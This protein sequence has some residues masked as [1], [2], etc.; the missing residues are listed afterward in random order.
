MNKRTNLILALLLLLVPNLW[1]QKRIKVACVGNSITEGYLLANPK[2]ES[3]PAVL[4]RL[5]GDGYEVGNFGHSG[6]TLL[7]EGHRPYTETDAFRRAMAFDADIFVVHLGLN[8]TDPRNWPNIKHLFERDYRKLLDTLGTQA[9]GKKLYIAQLSPLLPEHRRYYASSHAWHKEVNQ[10]I[11]NMA[12]LKYTLL[13]FSAPFSA[14]WHLFPDALHPNAEGAKLLGEYVYECIKPKTP[15]KLWLHPYYRDNMIIQKGRVRIHGKGTAGN[16]L[17]YRIDDKATN[18]TTIGPDGKWFIELDLKK[19]Q[20]FNLTLSDQQTGEVRTIR[21]IQV[22]EV[23]VASGQSN[24]QWTLGQTKDFDLEAAPADSLLHYVGM[25]AIAETYNV[26]WSLPVLDSINAFQYVREYKFYTAA[27]K[28][29]LKAWSAVGYHFGRKLRDSLQ[30]PVAIICNA[31]GGSPIEAWLNPAH[32]EEYYPD[33][34][35]SWHKKEYAEPWVRERTLKNIALRPTGQ[36]H[37]YAPGYLYQS[38]WVP[39]KD[40]PRR[41][42]IWYQGESNAHASERYAKHFDELLDIYRSGQSHDRDNVYAV[43][44]S[45]IRRPSWVNF[46]VAQANPKHLQHYVPAYDLGHPDDVHPQYKKPVG[47]RLALRALQYTYEHRLRSE[48]PVVAEAKMAQTATGAEIY[49]RLDQTWGGI[50][51]VEK[52]FVGFELMLPSGKIVEPKSIE[53]YQP[54]KKG[55]K[56]VAHLVIRN[57]PKANYLSVRYIGTAY[58]EANVKAGNG[59]PLM[60][61]DWIQIA[62]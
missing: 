59:M 28:E 33:M 45:S 29:S 47:E 43:Q 1:A 34:I 2:E 18:S 60:P 50:V 17:T 19:Y 23:W 12:G 31:V 13:D 35:T 6:A 52:G 51:P 58:T 5:L 55:A 54:K 24:M 21:N 46:R 22:G 40:I 3:Y 27:Q 39:I 4:Q 38:S 20:P 44:L 36:T 15:T 9:E 57:L 49:L 61:S 56:G 41:G 62:Q 8:D 7:F 30:C 25:P 32:L 16:T 11:A 14:R 26:E 53:V 10:V 48:A 37:P 42:V